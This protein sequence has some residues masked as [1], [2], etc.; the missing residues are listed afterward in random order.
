MHVYGLVTG[1]DR[2]VQ[3]GYVDDSFFVDGGLVV[4]SESATRGGPT[5]MR[6]AKARTGAPVAVPT[7]LAGLRNHAAPATDGEA[8]A[9][10]DSHWSSLWWSPSLTTAPARLF[11]ARGDNPI[12]NSIQ[13]AGRYI[14]FAVAPRAYLADTVSRRYIEIAPGG[15]ALLGDKSLVLETPSGVKA[16]HGISD[17]IFLPLSSLPAMPDR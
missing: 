17:V 8:I 10:A 11:A 1:R 3:R 6:A 14:S 15:W 7:S 12:D 9:F 4:W 16:L 2:V 13:V 5:S